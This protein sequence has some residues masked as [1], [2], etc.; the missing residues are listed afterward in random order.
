MS[1]GIDPVHFG[2]I[3]VTNIQIGLITPPMAANLFVSARI[4]KSSIPEMWPYV[5]RFL[6]PSIIGLLI[7]TYVPGLALWWK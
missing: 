6:I 3:L 1:F 7:I 5:L 2:I 4:N